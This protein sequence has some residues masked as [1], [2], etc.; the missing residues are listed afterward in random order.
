MYRYDGLYFISRCE[1][2]RVYEFFMI[3]LGINVKALSNEDFL[4]LNI[5]IKA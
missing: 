2:G 5:I 3:R 4:R 1:E